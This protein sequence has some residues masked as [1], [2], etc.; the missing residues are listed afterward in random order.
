LPNAMLRYMR[1]HKI[2]HPRIDF[3]KSLIHGYGAFAKTPIKRGE[4]IIEYVGE[5]IA[6]AESERRAALQLR[7]GK[8]GRQGSVYIFDL[9][10]RYDID[11][12][13]LWNP[14]RLINHSCEP[15][16]HAFIESN[17]I[18]IYTKRRICEGEELTYNYGY[19]VDNYDDHPCRC[20]K[21]SCVG[22]IVKRSQWNKLKK[23]I[24]A[25]NGHPRVI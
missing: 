20:G 24:D 19:D 17:R 18:W 2:E 9:N 23:M 10:S 7:R 5:K 4:K 12:N 15:N 22:Y 21:A 11:G 3:R 1:K 13:V 25:K 16:C 6:K 14:A 8:K